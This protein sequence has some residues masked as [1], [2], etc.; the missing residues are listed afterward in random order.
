MSAKGE[1]AA[2]MTP[3][4]DPTAALTEEPVVAASLLDEGELVL[5]AIRPSAWSVALMSAPVL[6]VAALVGLG[7]YLAGGEAALSGLYRGA[8]YLCVAAGCARLIVAVFQWMGRVYVHTN[9]RVQWISGVQ[10]VEV[11]QCPLSNVGGTR[12]SATRSERVVGIGTLEFELRVG[13]EPP[14]AW[15]NISRPKDVQQQVE[16]AIKQARR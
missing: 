4:G 12:L 3:A 5:L 11:F 10:R 14:G 16:S 7:A 15:I 13:R 8:V 6:I 2:T 9:R 1:G